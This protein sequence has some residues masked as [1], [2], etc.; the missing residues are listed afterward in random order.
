[1][2]NEEQ[3]ACVERY[4]CYACAGPGLIF[5]PKVVKDFKVEL[6]SG[7]A[8]SKQLLDERRREDSMAIPLVLINGM[9]C[10]MLSELVQ[11]HVVKAFIIQMTELDSL[12]PLEFVY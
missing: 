9:K 4:E 11:H 2:Y 10:K 7:A 1:M 3:R 5:S 8:V 6:K 12:N